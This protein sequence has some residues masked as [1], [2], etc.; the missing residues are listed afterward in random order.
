MK[1]LSYRTVKGLLE[2]VTVGPKLRP[3]LNMAST[4]ALSLSILQV[5]LLTPQDLEFYSYFGYSAY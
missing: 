3:L 5:F 2:E 4:T 1:N